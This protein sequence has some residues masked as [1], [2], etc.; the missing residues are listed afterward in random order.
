MKNF[1][2]LHHDMRRSM[3]DY[4]RK[5]RLPKQRLHVREPLWA[6]AVPQG[7]QILTAL[8]ERRRIG[9]EALDTLSLGIGGF[10]GHGLQQVARY[11]TSCTVPSQRTATNPVRLAPMAKTPISNAVGPP[12]AGDPLATIM[13]PPHCNIGTAAGTAISERTTVALSSL[14]PG[15]LPVADVACL[16]RMRY[17][18]QTVL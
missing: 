3:R 18:T 15:A 16:R 6:S 2:S 5:L 17:H 14:V 10:A 12:T 9:N 13:P 8:R 1:L 11:T 7:K 4:A